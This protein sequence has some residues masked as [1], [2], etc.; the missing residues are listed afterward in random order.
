VP[1][2]SRTVAVGKVAVS[3]G[4]VRSSARMVAVGKATVSTGGYA[5]VGKDVFEP[6]C[7]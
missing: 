7:V 2:F 4:V 6:A 5:V 1:W 3:I